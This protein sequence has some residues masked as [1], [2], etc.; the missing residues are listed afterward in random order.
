MLLRLGLV[1][2][3][4]LY[5]SSAG[6]ELV[7]VSYTSFAKGLWQSLR[8][9][10][11][12]RGLTAEQARSAEETAAFWYHVNPCRGAT[13]KA[14]WP[15]M[16]GVMLFVDGAR[17]DRPTEAATLEMMAILLRAD[18]GRATE[19]VCRFALETGLP[20]TPDKPR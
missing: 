1:V 10:S 17:S 6:A 3:A 2:I 9:V 4:L 8:E 13:P 15:K 16:N 5:S 7:N 11:A 20:I 18:K 14:Y 19:Y 12:A